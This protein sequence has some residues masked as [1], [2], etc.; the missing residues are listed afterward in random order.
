ML[1]CLGWQARQLRR[2]KVN[3]QASYL[4]RS[5]RRQTDPL[6]RSLIT[7]ASSQE[8][9]QEC[10]CHLA[11]QVCLLAAIEVDELD[12]GSLVERNSLLSIPSV[13]RHL[14][15]FWASEYSFGRIDISVQSALNV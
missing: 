15:W 4:G 6:G 13:M 2:S 8:H 5:H 11:I 3:S 10:L 14:Q 7:E 1:V 9:R 12:Q